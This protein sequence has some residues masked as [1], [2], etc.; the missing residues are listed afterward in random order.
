LRLNLLYLTYCLKPY[1]IVVVTAAASDADD[2]DD[3]ENCHFDCQFA[4]VEDGS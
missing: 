3:D 1:F 2:A 4:A